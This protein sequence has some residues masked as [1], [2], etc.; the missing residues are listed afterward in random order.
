MKSI[1]REFAYGNISPTVGAAKK[2][3]HYERIAKTLLDRETKLLAMLDGELAEI[4][5]QFID[6]QARLSSIVETDRFI[7]GYRLGV[8]M[9][10]DVFND[11]DDAAFGREN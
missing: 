11:Y 1:L 6:A 10:M 4:F 8:L 9:T 3:S 5:K 7:Y 2:D